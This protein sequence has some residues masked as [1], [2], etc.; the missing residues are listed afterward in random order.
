MFSTTRP[1]R[2]RPFP[3]SPGLLAA[4]SDCRAA[5]DLRLAEL[6]PPAA[7]EEGLLAGAMN[8]AVNSPGKRLR[9]ALVLLIARCFGRERARD[10][11]V[12]CAVELVHA[13]SLVLDD[14]PCMDD[15][16]TRRGQP[17]VHRRFGEAVAILAAFC[18][19]ARAQALLAAALAAA[20]VPLAHRGELEQRFAQVVGAL[21]R[22]QEQ[23][24]KLASAHA[25]LA[26]LERIHA[27]KTGALFELA[28]EL[29]GALA[30][31]RRR[32]LEALLA[33]ARNLG[34]AFQVG[35]DLLDARGGSAEI[36]KPTGQDAAL[37]RTTFVS[38]FGA[39]GA[40]TLRDELVAAAQEALAPLG[41]RCQLL[42]ELSEHVRTRTS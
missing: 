16:A 36:G 27:Q 3:G 25:N 19:L 15:A 29:G 33:W 6:V 28:A 42:K 8:A 35:D 18:L 24:L 26:L 10:L 14:L 9:P 5:V 32:Q 12:A 2:S 17:T 30:R 23:D 11:D 37:G 21:C 31:A 40:Q 22:G 39:A 41:A 38:V 13:A 1:R 4:L 34:L 20:G 7:A